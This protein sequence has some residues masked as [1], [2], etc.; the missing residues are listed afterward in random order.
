M[1]RSSILGGLVVL[2]RGDSEVIKSKEVSA[3]VAY[4]GERIPSQG[5]EKRIA[6][7]VVNL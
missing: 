4:L 5:S 3:E 2:S 1:A 7:Q 6:Y